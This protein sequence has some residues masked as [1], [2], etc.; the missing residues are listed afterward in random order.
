[1]RSGVLLK[2]GNGLIEVSSLSSSVP[3][4]R[5]LWVGPGDRVPVLTGSIWFLGESARKHPNRRTILLDPKSYRCS[6]DVRLSSSFLNH[7][8]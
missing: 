3:P 1:M 2:R 4:I 7:P 6:H 8:L 5:E